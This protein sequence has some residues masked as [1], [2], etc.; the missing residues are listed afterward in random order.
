MDTSLC[1]HFKFT[2]KMFLRTT[3]MQKGG[4]IEDAV[5]VVDAA[6]SVTEHIATKTFESR[7][8]LLRRDGTRVNLD[9]SIITTFSLIIY[10]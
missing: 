4:T 3:S 2:V 9:T 10:I 6:A 7:W 5:H 8:T 1:E